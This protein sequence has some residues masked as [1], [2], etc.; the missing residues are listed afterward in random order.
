MF[1]ACVFA[2]VCVCVYVCVRV[3][4]CVCVWAGVSFVKSY[5]SQ[6]LRVV[7][8]GQLFPHVWFSWRKLT[9]SCWFTSDT[10]HRV[11]V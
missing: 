11:P 8:P 5:F 10:K 7:T 4:M 3:C 2:W 9:S 6:R 1:F